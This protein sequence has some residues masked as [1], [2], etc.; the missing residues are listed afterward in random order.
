M[1]KLLSLAFTVAFM[2]FGLFLGVFNPHRVHFDLLLVQFDFPLGLA[3]AVLLIA[4]ML[5][6]ALLIKMQVTQL[7]W[8]LKK[9]T[10][11]NQK[12]ADELVHLK[13]SLAETKRKNSTD[14]ALPDRFNN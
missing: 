1:F 3:M 2:L 11:L 14:L 8:R 7:K 4:G 6:G 10:R 13:K 9:Q 12:Q 5:L